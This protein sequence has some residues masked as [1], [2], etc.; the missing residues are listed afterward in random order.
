MGKRLLALRGMALSVD[1]SVPG[2]DTG[3]PLVW[4]WRVG[5][6]KLSCLQLLPLPLTGCATWSRVT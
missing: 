6:E 2:P 4:K 5:V 3:I 1:P